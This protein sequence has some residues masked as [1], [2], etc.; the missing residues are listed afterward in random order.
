MEPRPYLQSI[1][2]N[3]DSI[4]SFDAYPFNISSI[5]NLS[6]LGFHADV[7]FIVGENGTGKSTLMEAIALSLG[8]SIEGGSNQ[9]N[10]KTHENSSSLNRYVKA[11]RSYKRPAEYFFLRAESFYNVATYLENAYGKNT[12]EDETKLFKKYY[13]VSSL[14]E[15]SHGE[16]FMALLSNKLKGNG[17]YLFDEPEAA[18]SPAR[19]LAAIGHIHRLVQK[20]SQF[21]IATHSPILLAYPNAVVYQLA[22]EGIKQINYEETEHYLITKYFL[23]NYTEMIREIIK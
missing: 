6:S 16:S 10:F 12:V 23:N 9:V 2:L 17:L 7:T 15:C 20:Q 3:R 21:I 18:L 4:P 11:I 14:H 22:E 13:G 5:R 1:Q 8:L 19:Q